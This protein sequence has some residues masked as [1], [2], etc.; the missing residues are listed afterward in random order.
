MSGTPGP[1]N[2]LAEQAISGRC[3]FQMRVLS[4]KPDCSSV[5]NE[6]KIVALISS[7]DQLRAAL[8]IADRGLSKR[9]LVGKRHTEMLRLMRSALQEARAVVKM[10]KAERSLAA[11]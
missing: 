4:L 5:T 8:I 1:H 9:K 2:F 10:A 3:I 7:N 11:T 6:D